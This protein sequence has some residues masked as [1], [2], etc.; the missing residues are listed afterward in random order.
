MTVARFHIKTENDNLGPIKEESNMD[1]PLSIENVSYGLINLSSLDSYQ[2]DDNKLAIKG[3]TS[4]YARQNITH[5]EDGLINSDYLDQQK[6][7]QKHK[8]FQSQECQFA[9]NELDHQQ[10]PTSDKSYKRV[11]SNKPYHCKKCCKSFA[12]AGQLETHQLI[13]SGGNDYQC[14]ECSKQFDLLD[15]LRKHLRIHTSEKPYQCQECL[16]SFTRSSS[17]NQHRLIHTGEKPY[18]CQECLKSFAEPG[19]LKRH[20]R[21]VHSGEKPYQC[22]ECLKSFKEPGKLKRHQLTHSGEKP[23]QCKE[24]FKNFAL[25]SSLKKHNLRI[26]TG[27]KPSYQC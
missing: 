6:A 9:Q 7:G 21:L 25:A 8:S 23:Y 14:Q 16:K 4:R 12:I 3:G 22:Q 1:D 24:C 10:V 13:H 11:S 5:G 19:N 17:L 15:N 20:Q 27:E 26:H 2:T 18:Q